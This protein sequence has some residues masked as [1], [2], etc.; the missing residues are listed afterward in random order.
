MSGITLRELHPSVMD[1]LS[2][3]GASGG[4]GVVIVANAFISNTPPVS[5]ENE[6]GPVV[7]Y[8]TDT[9]DDNN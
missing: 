8:D 3:G 7:W 5:S 9:G 2:Q 1:T 4:D 6:P